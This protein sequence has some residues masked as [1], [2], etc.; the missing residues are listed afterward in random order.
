MTVKQDNEEKKSNCQ[1]RT[2][3]QSERE[4]YFSQLYLLSR[5][6]IPTSVTLGDEDPSDSRFPLGVRPDFEFRLP[7]IDESSAGCSHC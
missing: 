1:S 3:I 2:A 7:H 5:V 4:K 6:N